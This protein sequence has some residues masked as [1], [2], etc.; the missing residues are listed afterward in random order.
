MCLE[1]LPLTP[2]GKVDRQSL[3][4]PGAVGVDADQTLFV[5]PRSRTEKTVAGIWA[6]VL[7]QERVG[8]YDNFFDLGGHSLS[9]TRVI[10]RLRDAF[11]IDLP[12]RKLFDLPTVSDLSK[13][14]EIVCQT[15]PPPQSISGD[16]DEREVIVL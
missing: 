4:Y 2:N 10:S 14:I 11:R 8:I 6:E 1:A 7:G 9:V 16:T 3:P 15:M 5:A 13:H 12:L